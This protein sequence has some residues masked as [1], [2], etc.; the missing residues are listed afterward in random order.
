[1]P[2]TSTC[3]FPASQG[4]GINGTQGIGVKTP[5]AD[6]V[7]DETVGFA[8]EEHIP[9][10]GTFRIPSLSMMV[11]AGS[12]LARTRFSGRTISRLGIVP[13]VQDISQD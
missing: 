9:N 12:S 11:A 10:V 7:A 4:A 13:K 6:E 1:M 2:P 5:W 8:S 3:G